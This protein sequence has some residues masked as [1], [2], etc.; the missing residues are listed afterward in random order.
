MNYNVTDIIKELKKIT[1]KSRKREFVDQ[2]SYLIGLLYYKFKLTEWNI[3]SLTKINRNKIHYN[4]KLPIRYKKN[5]DYIKHVK[6]LVVK[7]PYDFPEIKE[8]KSRKENSFI[9]I[10]FSL[11]QREELVKVQKKLN[12]REITI[13][14]RELIR[15]ALKNKIWEK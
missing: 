12:Q 3:S 11:Q 13:T 15:K 2:R 4:K 14:I 9:F 10:K 6:H 8:K 5:L 1:C 7:Y